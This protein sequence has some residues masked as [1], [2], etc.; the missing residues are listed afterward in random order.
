MPS[1]GAQ[2]PIV[3]EPPT[4]RNILTVDVEDY[5][6]AQ[7]VTKAIGQQAWD[8]C[9]LRVERNVQIILDLLDRHKVEATFFMLGWIAE[10][11]PSLVAAIESRGHE[12][13]V[14]G[15]AHRTITTMTPREFEDDL[16]KAIDI[17]GK[18]ACGAI[19]GFRAPSF[20]VTAQTLWALPILARN[21]LQYDSSIFPLGLH[22]EYGIPTAPVTI[23]RREGI[24][25]VPISCVDLPGFRAPAS[26]GG[27][28]RLLPYSVSRALMRLC[29]R[30]GY[31]AVFYFHPWE[32]DPGQPRYPLAGL[33]RMRHY[34]NL[35][36]TLGRLQRLL[37]D[38][39]FTSIRKA[40]QEWRAN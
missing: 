24:I 7:N 28:F 36:R 32:I 18:Q 6:C 21:G 12:I 9:E 37:S 20:S 25:E 34:A 27:Y 26:G 30:R 16:K 5:F 33:R 29:N 22:P 38:F 15:Y 17:I 14:H 8:S 40:L 1:L 2:L 35:G 19:R 10:R 23:H 3:V 31:P 13:A 4:L 11:V 39:S